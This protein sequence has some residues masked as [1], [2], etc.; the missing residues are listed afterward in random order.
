MEHIFHTLEH[1]FYVQNVYSYNFT[2]LK[3]IAFFRMDDSSKISYDDKIYL[4]IDHLKKGTYQLTILLE[5]K[6][7]KTFT[8]VK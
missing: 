6:V 2:I 8:I 1:V 7:I 4:S 3:L 5:N